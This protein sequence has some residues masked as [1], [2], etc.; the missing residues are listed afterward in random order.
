MDIPPWLVK[1]LSVLWLVFQR[2]T[3]F[4]WLKAK[5]HLAPASLSLL[6]LL[7]VGF[8]MP[9]GDSLER[10]SW[11]N[12]VM[13]TTTGYPIFSPYILPEQ[14]DLCDKYGPPIKNE[15]IAV[16][17]YAYSPIEFE[18]T[19]KEFE[20]H[21]NQVS[22]LRV[23]C[24]PCIRELVV[25]GYEFIEAFYVSAKDL[26]RLEA[27]S[28]L[29]K[30]LKLRGYDLYV[31]ETG[32][33]RYRLVDRDA[34]PALCEVFDVTLRRKGKDAFGIARSYG[35][36]S[37]S[38]PLLK[39]MDVERQ[40]ISV[41]KIDAPSSRY[42]VENI[43]VV[44]QEINGLIGGGLILRDSSIITD[45]RDGNVIASA[46]RFSYWHRYLIPVSKPEPFRPNSKPIYGYVSSCGNR[47]LSF[48]LS[49]I[50][51]PK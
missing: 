50:L 24:F 6:P 44:H 38:S 5:P 27:E 22:D 19:M 42:L 3:S 39:K 30:H 26:G 35:K 7:I 46:H 13:L 2:I 51:R 49:E 36:M 11:F 15:V 37:I 8:F 28:K 1:F 10:P 32:W 33:F 23:G 25:D 45:R 34:N 48:K 41:E 14:R 31:T 47:Q 12:K 17:G 9:W 20:L 4:L 43:R 40:C 29:K 18:K 21:P 16:K